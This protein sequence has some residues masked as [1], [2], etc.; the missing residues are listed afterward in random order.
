[1]V[2]KKENW[3]IAYVQSACLPGHHLVTAEVGYD[4]GNLLC[5]PVIEVGMTF[6]AVGLGIPVSGGCSL[7]FDLAIF[8]KE[9][10]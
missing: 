6:V 1:M 5:R 8:I 7:G 10:L 4:F 2:N 9:F 3:H